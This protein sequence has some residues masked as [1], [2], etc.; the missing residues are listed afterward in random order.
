MKQKDTRN[1]YC[2]LRN[3]GGESFELIKLLP[4]KT[5]SKDEADQLVAE[6]ELTCVKTHPAGFEIWAKVL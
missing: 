4:G 1:K 5:L 2:I 3:K 6:K